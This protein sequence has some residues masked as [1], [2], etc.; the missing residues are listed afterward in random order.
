MVE[1]ARSQIEEDHSTCDL[2][3]KVE[4]NLLE[5]H[6]SFWRMNGPGCGP[7]LCCPLP[8]FAMGP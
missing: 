3:L 5:C 7:R 1:R 8:C 2:G 4:G 6:G